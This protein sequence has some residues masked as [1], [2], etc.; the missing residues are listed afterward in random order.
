MLWSDW[1][2]SY[3]EIVKELG[4][5]AKADEKTSNLLD[6]FFI[7]LNSDKKKYIQQRLNQVFQKPVIIFGAGPSLD[8]DFSNILTLNINSR[9]QLV[10]INGATTLFQLKKV[11][12]SVVIS[13]LDGDLSTIKWAIENG[14]LTLIHAHGDNHDLIYEFLKEH[15]EII[16]RFDV[17]GTT[18]CKP[19][20]SLLNFG[21]FTDGDRAIFIAFHFQSPLIGLA[22]FDFGTKIGH[23][24]FVNSS[25]H[26]NN[27]LKI[28]KFEI[29]L[30][31]I[32]RF[33][34]FH[35]GLRFN[36]TTQGNAIPGFPKSNFHTFL[37]QLAE[38]YK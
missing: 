19:R 23:Y 38:Y 5:D 13:D 22:G 20:D 21:G 2:N 9:L 31:L 8:R 11:I 28:R 30:N 18:Q 16:S 1:K 10:S 26:K 32:A 27:E 29:A 17:W 33:H 35:K 37:D 4:L 6:E 7:K 3:N 34:S 14:A 25:V 12:P 36:L 24:S 15:H